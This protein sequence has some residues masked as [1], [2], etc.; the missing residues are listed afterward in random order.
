MGLLST[1]DDGLE[2]PHC[3]RPLATDRSSPR[4]CSQV[5]SIQCAQCD[6]WFVATSGFL[7]RTYRPS[8]HRTTAAFGVGDDY[9]SPD[10]ASLVRRHFRAEP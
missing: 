1:T 7:E 2:C 6:R 3:A 9:E 8:Y 5:A 4:R 10:V